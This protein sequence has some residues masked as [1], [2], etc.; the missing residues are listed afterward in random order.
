MTSRTTGSKRCSKTELSSSG[1]RALLASGRAG[2][3]VES[4]ERELASSLDRINRRPGNGAV[5]KH[6]R[7]SRHGHCERQFIV[8]M[9]SGGDCS[10]ELEYVLRGCL[11]RLGQPEKCV[12]NGSGRVAWFS[13]V[14]A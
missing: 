12:K 11:G 3:Q 4:H 8:R 14:H 6:R 1:S 10:E 7:A 9:G 5:L 13:L 2:L